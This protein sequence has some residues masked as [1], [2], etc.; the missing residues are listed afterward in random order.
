MTPDDLAG[1]LLFMAGD[2]G[3]MLNGTNLEIFSNA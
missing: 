2:S 1:I 3:G